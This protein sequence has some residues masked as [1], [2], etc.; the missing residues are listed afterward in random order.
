M[1]APRNACAWRPRRRFHDA[2]LH[3]KDETPDSKALRCL[4]MRSG[5]ADNLEAMMEDMVETERCK[6]RRYQMGYI[7]NE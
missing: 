7:K 5:T 3:P 2:A 4:D 1:G 6:T